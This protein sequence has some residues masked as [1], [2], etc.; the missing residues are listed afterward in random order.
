MECG[1]CKQ[2]VLE[3]EER[4]GGNH[5]ECNL[6]VGQC[7]SEQKCI[8]CKEPGTLPGMAVHER[9]VLTPMDRPTS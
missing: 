4:L 8:V 3:N 5:S 7:I 1:H 6:E 9:C 2:D